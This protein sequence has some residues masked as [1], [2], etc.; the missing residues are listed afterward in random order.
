MFFG[1]EMETERKYENRNKNLQNE[2]GNGFL[3]GNVNKNGTVFSGGTNV[4]RKL[5]VFVNI[6]FP[7][8][9]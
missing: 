4:E 9:L 8:L 2:N 6:E 3:C 7:F 5:S 1:E